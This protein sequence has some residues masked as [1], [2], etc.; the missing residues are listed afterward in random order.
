MKDIVDMYESGTITSYEFFRVVR[1]ELGVFDLPN[2]YLEK[3]VIWLME[4]P[5][6]NRTSC[7][8]A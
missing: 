2:E 1:D 7:I 8:S 3:Y 6:G 5:G 4:H